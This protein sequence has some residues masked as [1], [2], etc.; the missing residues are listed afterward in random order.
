MEISSEARFLLAG[1]R[2]RA[3][4]PDTLDLVD[5]AHL[6]IN[7]LIGRIRPDQDYECLWINTFAPPSISHH[8]CEWFETARALESLTLMRLITGSSH[9]IEIDDGMLPALLS[10]IGDD[11]LFY[12][13]PYRE[14]TPWRAGGYGGRVKWRTDD[15]VSGVVG[16]SQTLI[17][18]IDKLQL[19]DDSA[20][21][22]AARGL[23]DG[24]V[25]IAIRKEDYGYYPATGGTGLEFAYFKHSGWPDVEE[26]TDELQS[27]EG[28]VI[29]YIG[30]CVRALCR[31]YALTG[32]GNALETA[33][34]LVNY[35][36]KP[37]FWLANLE[38]WGDGI[39]KSHG[40]VQR[41]PAALFRGH[42]SGMA[43]ALHGLVEYALVAGDPYVKEFVR[44]GYEHM[45]NFGLVRLGMYGENIA[46]TVMA[47]VAIKLSDAGIGDF[48]EDVDQH[49]SNAMVEDQYIDADLIREECDR[50]GV[51]TENGDI[52]IGRFLGSLRHDGLI[53]DDGILDPTQNGMVA[54]H[55]LEPYYYVWEGITRYKGGAAQINLLLN[56]SAPWLDIDSHLPYDGKVEVRNRT[57]RTISLRIPRWVD[58]GRL[59]CSLDAVPTPCVWAGNYVVLA[60][61]SGGETVTLEFPMVEATEE[62]TLLGFN[63]PEAW[64]ADRDQL[65]QYILNLKG[66]TCVGVDFPNRGRFATRDRTGYPVYQRGYFRRSEAPIKS[67][68]RY[69]APGLVEW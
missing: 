23:A 26:A 28:T 49:I 61:L 12:N 5:R 63:P 34:R 52:T 18:L 6:A 32:E 50:R 3:T 64:F 44:Q 31:W 60:G 17:M 30:I 46:N 41:K 19:S 24:L 2:C 53:N 36:L 42:L 8:S 55:Y 29:C 66:N 57:A 35:M 59:K 14:N 62:Y 21:W 43:Y 13:A 38:T 9:R 16:N 7:A 1:D 58:R 67:L 25:R 47:A 22:E 20:L 39:W 48:W 11:G 40:G 68:T 56:R 33:R 69:V 65:P 54:S 45:R 4:V 37:R 27:A 10:R 51:P 15:D